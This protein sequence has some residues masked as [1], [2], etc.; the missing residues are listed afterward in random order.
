MIKPDESAVT[1]FR[2]EVRPVPRQNVGMEID[3]H[4]WNFRA[5]LRTP[6]ASGAGTDALQRIHWR[7]FSTFLPHF[8][9]VQRRIVIPEI[10]HRLTEM[11]NDV[12]A[13]EMD[14]FHQCAAI[15]AVKNNVLF[16]SRRPAPFDHDTNRIR[17]PLR[18]VRDIRRDK[19]CFACSDNMVHDAIAFADAHLDVAL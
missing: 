19:E 12:C 18:R 14:V 8:L 10:E 5:F 6:K 3:F 1:V 9:Q 15:L 11:L 4:G 13:V 7:P 2:I 16:F 17:R